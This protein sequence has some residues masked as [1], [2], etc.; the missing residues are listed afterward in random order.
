MEE[1]PERMMPGGD[2][3]W[4]DLGEAFPAWQAS[5]P[6]AILRP[7]KPEIF[8]SARILQLSAEHDTGPDREATD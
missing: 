7:P 2:P 8:P 1:H 5:G 6:N 4:G 3:V